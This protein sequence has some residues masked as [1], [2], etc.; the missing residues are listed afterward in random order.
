M[1]K[2]IKVAILIA[3]FMGVVLVAG[4]Y[5]H[6]HNIAVFNPKGTIAAKERSLMI[7]TLLL[8]VI[9]VL[10]VF[11]LTFFI[12]WRYRAT[13]K[14]AKYTPDW[15]RSRTLE[16]FWWAIP[17]A[18]IF[19]L[20]IVTWRSSHE[21]DPFQPI[22]TKK[23]LLVQVV[24]LDWKWLFIYPDQHIA[25]VNYMD[26]PVNTPVTF[27]ITSD[28]PM[29]SFWVPQLGGQIYAMSGMT[30]KLHLQ[31]SQMGSY[32]GSSANISGKGF[33]GMHFVVNATSAQD[34]NAWVKQVSNSPKHLSQAGYD[35]LAQPSENNPHTNYSHV[36]NELYNGVIAKYMPGHAPGHI[37]TSGDDD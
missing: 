7:F 6:S 4:W 34:Y 20:A 10:P 8:S 31:A 9:V 22:S 17:C 35:K 26:I 3:L 36:Q 1:S 23:P 29:N 28:A 12:V 37:H 13:N 2:K 27:E 18:I 5:V 25:T 32:N 15:D 33:A 16:F 11:T 19:V 30:T 24:A 21:L 14:K